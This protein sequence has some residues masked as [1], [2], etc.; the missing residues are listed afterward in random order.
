MRLSISNL[1]WDPAHDDAIAG[2]LQ[3]FAVDAI[4]I[5]P[6][7]YFPEPRQVEPGSIASVRRAW[8]DRGI[9]IV[10]MQSLLFRTTGL[11][12]F[13]SR[14][15]Q[16]AMLDHLAH[17]ARIGAGLG[18]GRLVFGSPKNRDRQGLDMA[19][20]MVT[21][22][23]FFR[24]LGDIAAS[25]GCIVC[26]EPNPASYGCNFMTTTAEAAEVVHHTAHPSIRL[27]FDIGAVTSNG[28]DAAELLGRYHALVGHVHISEPGLTPLG[29]SQADHARL[30]TLLRR[31]LPPDMSVSIEM[32]TPAGSDQID[33]VRGAL[34]LATQYY[35]DGVD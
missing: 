22:T 19:S 14:A 10:A 8:R 5:A 2:L 35:R 3:G 4:E 31:L 30:G 23:G 12:L 28:E 24:R 32:L 11:N 33:T 15:V 25:A 20:A 21:A 34:Q 16:D 18:A 13:S 26:L 7:K 27:Q 6:T 1:A 17:I 29:S 9:D